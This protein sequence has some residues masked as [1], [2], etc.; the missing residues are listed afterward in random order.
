MENPIPRLLRIVNDTPILLEALG[1][2]Y[3][4][5]NRGTAYTERY[6][7]IGRKYKAACASLN[8]FGKGV[9]FR[10]QGTVLDT[11]NIHKTWSIEI[12][13]DIPEVDMIALIEFR[14]GLRVYTILKTQVAILGELKIS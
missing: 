13:E 10:Y 9:I 4:Y 2:E 7:G 14:T 3:Q 5:K 11:D 8:S 12:L 6:Q 1:Y